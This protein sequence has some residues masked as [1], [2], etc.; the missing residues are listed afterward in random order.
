[1]ECAMDYVEAGLLIL[2]VAAGSVIAAD[3]VRRALDVDLRRRQHEVG[4][5]LYMQIGV[6]FAVLLAF[7]FNEVFGEYNAAAQAI[8]GECGALHGAA[9]LANDLSDG[10][11]KVVEQAILD[12]CRIV[13]SAEWEALSHRQPSVD[14]QNA[15]HKIVL[16]AGRLNP[17]RSTDS[18]I[19]SQLLSLISQAHAFRET[20]IFQATQGLPITIWVVLL[21]YSLL[22][23]AF[24]LAGVES[25]VVHLFFTAA[26]STSVILV[27]IVVRMLDYPFEGALTLSNDDFIKT[28]ARVSALVGGT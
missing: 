6:V 23:V 8:N 24:V 13:V 22:L 27:L 28:I 10:Q 17:T 25:R 14:A 12:Y 21:F 7:V 18:A 15:F 11:G 2:L 5:P 20:R 3:L 4:N 19:Q 9:M 16:A 26:F 1:M